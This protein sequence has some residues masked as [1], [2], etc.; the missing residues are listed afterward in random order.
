MYLCCAR[1][2]AARGPIKPMPLLL[3]E[4]DDW[5]EIDALLAHRTSRGKRQYL[6]KYKGFDDF[7]NEWRNENDVTGVAT[8]EYWATHS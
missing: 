5:Y 3:D 8:T 2:R 6:V 1:T 7:H 4:G